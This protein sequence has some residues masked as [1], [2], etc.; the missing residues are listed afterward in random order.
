MAYDYIHHLAEYKVTANRS[1]ILMDAQVMTAGPVDTQRY[2][3]FIIPANQFI[4][5]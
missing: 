2:Q 3:G 4:G 1:K 5:S